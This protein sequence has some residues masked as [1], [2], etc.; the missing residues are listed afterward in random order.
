MGTLE[1]NDIQQLLR[2]IDPTTFGFENDESFN[3]GLLQMTLDEPV[4]LQLCHI[5][6]H[7]CDYQLQYRIE[8]IIAFSEDFVGRLQADQKRRYQ[9]LKE[10]SL[11]PAIMA[12]KTR[13]FRCPPKDQMQALI[14]FKEDLTDGTLFNE[15][16]EDEIKE[17]LKDFHSTLVTIQQIVQ[18]NYIIGEQSDIKNMDKAEQISLFS[19]LLEI[20]IR[21][22]VKKKNEEIVL[23]EKQI[24]SKSG[25]TLS[26]VIKEAVIQWGRSTN[27]NDHNL[28][29]EMFKL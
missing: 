6:Q 15:D 7:L 18:T 22:A 24:F 4:K 29:R 9:V 20:L 8:G 1:V 16:I 25:K 19:R 17:M 5:L 2:L 27:I 10:L 26:E 28:I 21:H 13:E 23:V 3:E 11:P 14:N 12:R